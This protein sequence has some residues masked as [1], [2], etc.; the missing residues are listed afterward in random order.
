MLDAVGTDE[1]I[2]ASFE[3]V[4]DRSHIGTIVRGADAE[5]WGIQAWSGGSPLP[6]TPQQEAW[7]SEGI[8]LAAQLAAAG[9]FDVEIARAFPLDGAVEATTLA[10]GGGVRGKIVLL[11]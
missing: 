3:L 1:A 7:R 11:P 9:R 10:E 2:E 6:L 8:A 4:S 5:G